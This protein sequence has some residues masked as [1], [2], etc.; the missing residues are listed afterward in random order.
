MK[1]I[2]KKLF[3]L[4]NS[5]L[6]IISCSNA[7]EVID[8]IVDHIKN[9]TPFLVICICFA[10]IIFSIWI[11]IFK[12]K[13]QQAAVAVS[14]VLCCF[15]M[16]PLVIS[17]THFVNRMVMQTILNKEQEKIALL[18]AEARARTLESQ[19]L[20]YEIL[21]ARQSIEFETLNR[22]NMLLERAKLQMQG[23]QQITELALTQANIKYTLVRKEP[24]TEISDSFWKIRAEHYH[25][26]VLVVSNYDINAKF[27]ID[28]NEVKVTKINNN[29]VVV[30]GI[31]PK[32]IGTDKWERDNLVKEIRRVDYKY[33]EWFRTRVLD[34]R[35]NVILADIK[36]QQFDLEFN[37]K[38]SEGMELTFMDNVIVQ[39]AKNFIKI[40]LVPIFDDI[41]F[42]DIERSGALSLMDFL[43]Q[44][45]RESDEEKFNL[46]QISEQI[47]LDFSLFDTET[48]ELEENNILNEI[49][50]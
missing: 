19:R 5:S 24:T 33:G 14:S 10:G 25:D 23:F 35:Q 2:N 45:L 3:I 36:E 44:E 26:E 15:I 8:N 28:L 49:S 11:S 6:L 7:I 20:D 13:N 39:L 31:R 27:G 37:R 17:A 38:V 40:V 41:E 29:S 18:R 12:I 21:L 30:S 43:T 32:F 34:A 48:S 46:L 16:I 50:E 22:R 47:V 9:A 4:I 42:D 1:Y